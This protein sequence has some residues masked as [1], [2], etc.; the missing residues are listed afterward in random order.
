MGPVDVS[1]IGFWQVMLAGF[2]YVLMLESL[3]DGCV[4]RVGKARACSNKVCIEG[5]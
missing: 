1:V 5:F 3:G 2:R 4:E